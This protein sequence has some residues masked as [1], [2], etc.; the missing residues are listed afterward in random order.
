MLHTIPSI[1]NGPCSL[2]LS[3][4]LVDCALRVL[5]R[6]NFLW[7]R[8]CDATGCSDD[9]LT[10]VP[11]LRGKLV[12]FV[13]A[14]ASFRYSM[15]N[16]VQTSSSRIRNSHILIL[17]NLDNGNEPLLISCRT[18]PRLPVS[19]SQLHFRLPFCA[20]SPRCGGR[21]DSATA[22]GFPTGNERAR[23]PCEGRG[24]TRQRRQRR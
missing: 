5:R 1:P 24:R 21:P 20:A 15:I 22:T 12:Y 17:K 4:V 6:D 16:R 10:S 11:S 8:P 13:M 14:K 9:V 7:G 2:S 18:G 19:A 23:A 3:F